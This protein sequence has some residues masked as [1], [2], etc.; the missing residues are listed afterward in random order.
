MRV[1][2]RGFAR[3]VLPPTGQ[4]MEC[5]AAGRQPLH[6]RKRE[7]R[8]AEAGRRLEQQPA[9]PPRGGT[10]E[11]RVTAF[12]K[13]GQDHER[14]VEPDLRQLDGGSLD[15]QQI[16][17]LEGSL[18]PCV[19]TTLTRHRTYVRSRGPDKPAEPS[20]AERQRSGLRQGREYAAFA[21]STWATTSSLI[22]RRWA[23]E[24]GAPGPGNHSRFASSAGSRGSFAVMVRGYQSHVGRPQRVRDRSESEP[25]DAGNEVNGSGRR[26]SIKSRAGHPHLAANSALR[27]CRLTKGCCLHDTAGRCTWG[28]VSAI[29]NQGKRV[30]L[31]ALRPRPSHRI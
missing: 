22:A 11:A 25:Q 20:D 14:V 3:A 4:P 5:V 24:Y 31:D 21:R 12:G 17:S 23:A 30:V 16:A 1:D 8:I 15:D 13:Q 27:W 18:K 7:A 2:R 29:P 19:R 9:E 28:A 10:I 6:E 26:S